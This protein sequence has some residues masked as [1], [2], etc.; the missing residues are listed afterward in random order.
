MNF[1]EQNLTGKASIDKPWLNFYPEEFRNLD[2]PRI[3]MESFLKMKNPDENRAAFE[4]YGNMRKIPDEYYILGDC[5]T[6]WG[7]LYIKEIINLHNIRF[8]KINISEDSFFNLEYSQF[9]TNISC[10]FKKDYYYV[11][12]ENG[13]NLTAKAEFSYFEIYQKLYKEYCKIMKTEIAEQIIY[14]QYYNLLLKIVKQNKIKTIKQNKVINKVYAES[15]I[16]ILQ[17][18]DGVGNEKLLIKLM[19]MKKW[20]VLKIIT[21]L[22]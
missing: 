19:I 9:V 17:N 14:P 2:I 6:I 7:K 21:K 20:G 5:H 1:A 12:Y 4:Y 13:N 10:I 3:T 16:K 8:K 22:L 15:M 11:Q 18:H